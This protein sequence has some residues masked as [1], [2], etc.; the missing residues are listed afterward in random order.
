MLPAPLSSELPPVFTF[1]TF[2]HNFLR[3]RYSLVVFGG[4]G[5]YNDP[6]SVIVD[7]SAFSFNTSQF[8]KYFEDIPVGKFSKFKKRRVCHNTFFC[9]L[10]Q[11]NSNF[12][13]SGY[14]DFYFSGNGSSDIF[15]ALRFATKFSLRT[16][17]SKC[18]I[19]II[20]SNCDP[21][22]MEVGLI[23]LQ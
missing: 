14:F 10:P 12:L 22:N 11:S 21:T 3:F 19:L 15:S 9:T 8:I 23:S 20:C 18:F 7:S 16:G 2:S 5:I 6:H 17:V 4:E 1:D 13:Q